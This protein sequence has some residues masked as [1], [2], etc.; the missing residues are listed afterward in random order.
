MSGVNG[1]LRVLLVSERSPDSLLDAL[2]DGAEVERCTAEGGAL[3]GALAELAELEPVLVLGQGAA[4]QEVTAA[5]AEL[6]S[7][8]P[9][10]RAESVSVP[11]MVWVVGVPAEVFW[12]PGA[13]TRCDA[14]LRCGE[15]QRLPSLIE[16][17]LDD[18]QR[19]Q[20]VWLSPPQL[21]ESVRAA[22]VTPREF[23]V[24]CLTALGW[25]NRE[26]ARGLAIGLR[27]VE[28]HLAQLR[29]K[30]VMEHRGRLLA[31]FWAEGWVTA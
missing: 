9:S 23:E 27:T 29:G 31:R 21:P 16:A 22:D 15:Q 12:L 30:L 20:R 17:L 10:P 24:G 7:G 8:R 25:G 11:L 6:Q 14:L 19:L 18:G 28:Y 5:L 1:P 26:I 3:R 4:P 2:P 13:G